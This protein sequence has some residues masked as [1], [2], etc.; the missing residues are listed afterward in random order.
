MEN[1]NCKIVRGLCDSYEVRRTADAITGG[2][3]LEVSRIIN[4]GDGLC[5]KIYLGEMDGSFND[6][7]EVLLD[8]IDCSFD[9]SKVLNS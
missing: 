5:E 6:R 4:H 3:V 8:E 7:D 2:E 1:K 9:K